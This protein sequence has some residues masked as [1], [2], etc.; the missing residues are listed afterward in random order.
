MITNPNKSRTA[1]RLLKSMFLAKGQ[2]IPAQAYVAGQNWSDSGAITSH[3]KGIVTGMSTSDMALSPIAQDFSATVRPL[4][5][6]GRLIGYRTVPPRIRVLTGASGTGASF[7]GQGQA[8]PVSKMD[9]TGETLYPLKIAAL[10][11]TT[12]ELMT[13]SS[14]NAD[15]ILSEDLAAAAAQALDAAFI[16]PANTGTPDVMP[17]SVTSGV[18]PLVS[19]GAT[20]AAI[21]HDLKAMLQQLVDAGSTLRYASWVLPVQTAVAL[22]LL[23]GTG[24]TPAYPGITALGGVL[25]GLP[26]VPSGTMETAGSPSLTSIVLIDGSAIAVVDDGSAEL[27]IS[28]HASIQMTDNPTN[29][30]ATPTNVVSSFQTHTAAFRT[31]LYRN[32]I[33]RRPGFVS[34]LAGVSY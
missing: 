26:V 2:A 14:P 12:Q 29:S 1:A 15:L 21:D 34:V 3:L 33:L 10:C 24:G 19:T 9:L 8:I 22:S 11:L 13:S 17:A 16:D 4:T 30:A 20:I 7:L 31:V 23:R 18:T 28:E 27:A 32:W 6:L 25:L 5:I